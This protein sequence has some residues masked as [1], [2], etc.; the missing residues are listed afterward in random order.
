MARRT[1]QENG[2]AGLYGVVAIQWLL[3]F[4]SIR[5]MNP[6][7]Y[8]GVACHRR[9]LGRGIAVDRPENQFN[10]INNKLNTHPFCT[11]IKMRN[12]AV[13]FLPPSSAFLSTLLPR[14]PVRSPASRR[15]D[16]VF[17]LSFCV[18]GVSPALSSVRAHFGSCSELFFVF[19]FLSLPSFCSLFFHFSSQMVETPNHR[20]VSYTARVNGL[21]E[22]LLI[23]LVNVSQ[24][25][26]K[27]LRMCAGDTCVPAIAGTHAPGRGEWV[28]GFR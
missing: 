3:M 28:E 23:N 17:P 26:C 7:Y 14:S 11:C 18:S 15:L 8:Y 19:F 1:F 27:E 10:K 2:V 21:L 20:L 22:A 6:E 25:I 12:P 16:R 9:S 4:Y 13:P 5:Y 24:N